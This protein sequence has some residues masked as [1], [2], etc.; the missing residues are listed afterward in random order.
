MRKRSCKNILSKVN[1]IS[2]GNQQNVGDFC[3]FMDDNLAKQSKSNET[4]KLLIFQ[5][6]SDFRNKQK[7]GCDG[8]DKREK[9]EEFVI[10]VETLTATMVILLK[11]KL[12]PLSKTRLLPLRRRSEK[13]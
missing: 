8:R 3:D 4:L 9:D 5:R 11:K 6:V 13:L 7:A 10:L 1:V 12:A 2:I